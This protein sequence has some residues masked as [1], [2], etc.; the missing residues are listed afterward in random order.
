M[1]EWFTGV[2]RGIST[3]PNGKRKKVSDTYLVDAMGFTEAENVLVK[4]CF[5]LYGEAKVMTLKREVIEEVSGFDKEQWWKVVIGISDITPKGK[6]KIRRYNHIVSA[7]NVSQAKELITER[8]KGTIGDWKI[9][10]IEVTRFKDIIIHS[11][12]TSKDE[13]R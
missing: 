9:L 13:L 3:L 2:V 1:K 10:K 7:D 4:H 5:P 6:V 11:D 8:M 12:G